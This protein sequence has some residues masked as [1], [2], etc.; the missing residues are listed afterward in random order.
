MNQTLSTKIFRRVSYF[1]L[2]FSLILNFYWEVILTS[3]FQQMKLNYLKLILFGEITDWQIQEN[4][5][6]C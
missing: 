6:L 4:F 2:L 5:L 1:L 3:F